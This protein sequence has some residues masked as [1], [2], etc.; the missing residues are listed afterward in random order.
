MLFWILLRDQAQRLFV[1]IEQNPLYGA[2]A[3]KRLEMAETDASIQGYEDG[4]FWERNAR[5]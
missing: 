3:Q 5:R 2:W 4:V 1:A